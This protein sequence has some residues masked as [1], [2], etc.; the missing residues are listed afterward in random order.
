MNFS[1]LT[2]YWY[3]IE[4]HQHLVLLLVSE[5]IRRHF[6]LNVKQ[7]EWIILVLPET[8]TLHLQTVQESCCHSS[9]GRRFRLVSST[10]PFLRLFLV[11]PTYARSKEFT[12]VNQNTLQY[13][14]SQRQFKNTITE[15][16][17]SY[18]SNNSV[19]FHK[20]MWNELRNIYMLL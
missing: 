5:L 17:I 11:L 18:G 7:R 20:W 1:G 19:V 8:L 16:K 4:I 3:I 13:H 9:P 10:H 15:I 2:S 14:T 12:C 6:W